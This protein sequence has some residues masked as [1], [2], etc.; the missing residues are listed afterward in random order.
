M[1]NTKERIIYLTGLIEDHDEVD[2]ICDYILA[3]PVN[4]DDYIILINSGGGDCSLAIQIINSLHYAQ[5]ICKRNTRA[6]VSGTAY[7]CAADI[8]LACDSLQI[9]NGSSLLFHS[10]RMFYHE[11]EAVSL[12]KCANDLKMVKDQSDFLNHLSYRFFINDEF[13]RLQNGEDIYISWKDEYL[14][15]RKNAHFGYKKIGK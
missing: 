2:K 3:P 1:I 12:K 8:A 5:S 11:N 10:S 13:E 9:Q 7:S 15:Q 14:T 6:I 4:I